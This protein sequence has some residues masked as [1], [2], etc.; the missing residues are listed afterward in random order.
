MFK[1]VPILR[2]FKADLDR[3][4]IPFEDQDGRTVDRHSLRTTFVSWLGQC[5]VDPRAQL[6][7]ARHAPTGVTLKHYQ[8]FSLFDLWAE[9]GKLPGPNGESRQ[10]ARATGTEDA[11]G[12]VHPVVHT[13][14]I[15][16]HLVAST[17]TKGTT[18]GRSAEYEDPTNKVENGD[19]DEEGKLP[20]AGLEPATSCSTGRRSSQLSYVGI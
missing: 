5:G 16:S 9:I 18:T 7:L 10:A 14:A 11:E 17:G 15:T 6:Q 8:D 1:T 3:A 19:S 13:P 20:T 12:F 4:G 2:T